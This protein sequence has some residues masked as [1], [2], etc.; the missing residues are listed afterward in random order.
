LTVPKGTGPFPAVVLVHG[1]GPSDQDESVGA[2]KVFKDLA[3][4]LASHGIVALRYTK[5][6][7]QSPAGI[8]TQKEE[9]LDAAH[10]AIELL[11]HADRIDS[12]RIFLLGHSQGGGLA[13]RIAKE[14]PSLAGIIVLAGNTRALQDALLDQFLYFASLHPENTELAA[15]IDAVRKFKQVVEDPALRPD[16]DVELPTGGSLKGAYF[17]D[18]R[19]YDAPSVAQ[20]LSCRVLVMQGERDYQVTMK[21]FEDWKRR[22]AHKDGV[23][24]R[25]YPSLNHLFVSGSGAPTP[26][27]YER[28]GHVD[29]VVIRDIAQWITA[30]R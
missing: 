3:W 8:V 11:R 30:G 2:V 19:G 23:I 10:D 21:D 29:E 24:L 13:P 26:S 1:S 12:S 14:N 25:T 9:V 27:E 20:A 4:G 6:T 17:L 28:P 5:R 7:R 22:L 16:Q 15:K 18:A